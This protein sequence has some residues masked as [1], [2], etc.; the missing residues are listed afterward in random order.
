MTHASPRR[1]RGRLIPLRDGAARGE[2]FEDVTVGEVVTWRRGRGV[3]RQLLR[4]EIRVALLDPL[5]EPVTA[6]G[7]GVPLSVPVG[8]ELLGRVI[9]PL[10]RSRDGG[11]HLRGEVAVLGRPPLPPPERPPWGMRLTGVLALDLVLPIP[12]GWPTMLVGPPGSGRSTL[13]RQM[14][15]SHL[16]RGGR[17]IVVALPPATPPEPLENAVVITAREHA[18]PALRALALETA[19]AICERWQHRDRELWLV[20]DDLSV[21]AAAAAAEAR[22]LGL[23]LQGDHALSTRPRLLAN[24]GRCVTTTIAVMEDDPVL[25]LDTGAIRQSRR[26]LIFS[27]ER[28]QRGIYPPLD[29]YGEPRNGARARKAPP[30]GVVPRLMGWDAGRLWCHPLFGRRIQLFD[31]EARDEHLQKLR[32]GL[33]TPPLNELDK[34]FLDELAVAERFFQQSAERSYSPAEVNLLGI[35]VSRLMPADPSEEWREDFLRWFRSHQPELWAAIERLTG[36]PWQRLHREERAQ[37]SAIREV[38]AEEGARF[39][40]SRAPTEVPTT[41]A[42][43]W[44]WLRSLS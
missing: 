4:D 41:G 26:T 33:R 6:R 5:R 29:V 30:K 19:C 20:L 9:D 12:G 3:V 11:P 44:A 18:S 8:E 22:A 36:R 15:R 34:E 27:E 25:R 1:D 42:R 38:I 39:Q 2:G 37:L 10:G 7:T 21:W 13:A 17:A 24:L 40:E 14:L 43:L 16:Q 28:V 23:P 31:R 35:A 32:P